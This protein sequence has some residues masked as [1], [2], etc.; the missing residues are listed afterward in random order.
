MK[1]L[2]QPVNSGRDSLV[3]IA[4][5]CMSKVS[6]SVDLLLFRSFFHQLHFNNMISC[7]IENAQHLLLMVGIMP[8]SSH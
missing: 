7:C 3:I 6:G 2:Q 5:D 8:A 4:E 1:L